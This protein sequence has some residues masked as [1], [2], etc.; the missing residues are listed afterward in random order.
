MLDLLSTTE[1]S[2]FYLGE[3]E[4]LRGWVNHLDFRAV[5]ALMASGRWFLVW[6]TEP[7][8]EHGTA[9]KPCTESQWQYSLILDLPLTH[10]LSQVPWMFWTSVFQS[11]E[12]KKGW[13]WREGLK[14]MHTKKKALIKVCILCCIWFYLHDISKMTDRSAVAAW[15]WEYEW[16]LSAKEACGN[17]LSDGH[18]WNL[19]V[20]R[21]VHCIQPPETTF[22]KGNF[23]G[24]QM[25]LSFWWFTL[26]FSKLWC[27]NTLR[28]SFFSPLSFQ[29]LISFRKYLAFSCKILFVSDDSCQL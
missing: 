24:I 25:I 27:K 11:L 28:Q 2:S 7:W 4:A 10:D 3:S 6:H 29:C 23:H 17:L 12:I 9:G 1:L 18:V 22:K 5:S 8:Q 14:N 19:I 15:S 21:V 13:R 16:E 26:G 20:V